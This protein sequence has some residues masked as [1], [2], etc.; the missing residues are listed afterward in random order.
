MQ[1]RFEIPQSKRQ[2]KIFLASLI[3]TAALSPALIK[4]LERCFPDTDLQATQDP[5]NLGVNWDIRSMLR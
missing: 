5:S 4:G 2:L 3:L 1:P